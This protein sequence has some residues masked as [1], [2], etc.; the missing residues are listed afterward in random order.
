MSSLTPA[1][2]PALQ[3]LAASRVVAYA[4]ETVANRIRAGQI[5][6]AGQ[7]PSGDDAA[8]LAA[9]VAAALAALLGVQR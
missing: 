2:V 9:A 7:V 5:V 3:D 1:V 8:S 4:L 6:V